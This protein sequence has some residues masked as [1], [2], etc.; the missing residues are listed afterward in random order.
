M[1]DLAD[2]AANLNQ[3]EQM[4]A[5]YR[6]GGKGKQMA[7]HVIYRD[8]DCPHEGCEHKLQAIDFRL[9]EHGRAVHDALVKAWWD[10]IGFVGRCPSCDGWIH[11]TIQYKRPMSE[12]EA[13]N[14]PQLP[15]DWFVKATVL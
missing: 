11:F 10:D 12:Q 5:V 1:S 13:S 6:A 2:T 9:E 15:D 4:H 8:S 3:R 7:P 14:L